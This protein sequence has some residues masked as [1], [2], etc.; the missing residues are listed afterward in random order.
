[1]SQCSTIPSPQTG[2]DSFLNTIIYREEFKTMVNR[3]FAKTDYAKKRRFYKYEAA[4]FILVKLYALISNVSTHD[5]AEEL[6]MLRHQHSASNI[7]SKRKLYADNIRKSRY[8]P[9]QTDVDKFIRNL[10]EKDIKI[11]CRGLLDYLNQKIVKKIAPNRTWWSMADNTKYPYYGPKNPIKHIKYHK[12][13]GTSYG[14]FFQGISMVSKD[15]HLYTDI[16]SLSKGVYRCKD[17]PA[18][19]KWQKQIICKSSGALFDREFYRAALVAD[20]NLNGTKV[21]IPTIKH[22]WVKYKIE[23]YLHNQGDFVIGDVFKQS[24][25]SYPNQRAA[26]MRLVLIGKANMNVWDIKK[27]FTDGKITYIDAF[28]QINGFYTNL[29]PWK[30]KKNWSHFLRKTYKKRWN[31]ETGFVM[32]NK[33]AESSR[34]RTY[35]IKLADMYFRAFLYDWWQG[36]RYIMLKHAS[37]HRDTTQNKFRLFCKENILQLALNY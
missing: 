25:K 28:E 5:A 9:H 33:F 26:F 6:N 16:F 23:Q 30:N 37:Y 8:I 7:D 22:K 3:L 13:Q 34:S 21:I 18:A 31:I 11:L 2:V 1:M 12:F 27:Q 17:V 29:K 20:L 14:W 4:D 10:S 36:W 19:I 15:I 35:R 32:V 24:F